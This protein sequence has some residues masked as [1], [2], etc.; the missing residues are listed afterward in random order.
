YLLLPTVYGDISYLKNV[1]FLRKYADKVIILTTKY[2][3]AEF[4]TALEKVCKENDLRYLKVDVPRNRDG[5]PNKN[6]Y[7]IYKGAFKDIKQ[8]GASS[9]TPCVLIDADTYA[10]K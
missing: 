5:T 10:P 9:D 3:T 6:P 2:E 8:L 4:Y 1:S 7:T